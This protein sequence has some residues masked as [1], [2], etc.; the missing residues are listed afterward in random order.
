MFLQMASSDLRTNPRRGTG[1]QRDED[2]EC[3]E[4]EP[5]NTSARASRLNAVI[6]DSILPDAS[7]KRLLQIGLQVL[8]GFQAHGEAD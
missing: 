5:K 7:L 1:H 2:E 3:T 4:A 6:H 8:E